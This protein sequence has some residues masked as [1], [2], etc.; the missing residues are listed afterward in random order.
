MVRGRYWQRVV[1]GAMGERAVLVVS[2]TIAT[3]IGHG[4]MDSTPLY[5]AL[6]RHVN[7]GAPSC[8]EVTHNLFG[9][10]TLLMIAP[11]PRMLA[12]HS[13][14]E[15]AQRL[16]LL[17]VLHSSL[18]LSPHDASTVRSAAAT[19]RPRRHRPNAPHEEHHHHRETASILCDSEQEGCRG[20]PI[21]WLVC[22]GWSLSAWQQECGHGGIGLRD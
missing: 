22:G 11:E 3:F 4:L 2:G 10:V 5:E 21:E 15:P 16:N 18:L 19:I 12:P 13:Q 8:Q 1:G 9:W 20:R 6:S 14:G 7:C 17:L